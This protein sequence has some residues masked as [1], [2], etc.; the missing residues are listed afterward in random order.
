M[1]F[2]CSVECGSTSATKVSYFSGEKKTSQTRVRKLLEYAIVSKSKFH[3]TA[4]PIE[5]ICEGHFN[6]LVLL[7]VQKS[8]AE[9][10]FAIRRIIF[11]LFNFKF[12]FS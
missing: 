7:V 11:H 3:V 9:Q 4:R 12:Q 2:D 1:A 8:G 5:G 10:R 6:K